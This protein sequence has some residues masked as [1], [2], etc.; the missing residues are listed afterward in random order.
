MRNYTD[1]ELIVRVWDQEQIRDLISRFTYFEAA[2]RRAEALDRF[3][4][5]SPEHKATAS[6]GR[7]WG[8]ITGMDAIRDYYVDR[9]RFGGVGTGLMHPLSTKLICLAG[10][11]LTARGMW[12][13]IAYETA[14]DAKGELEA[15]WINERL[16]VD[17]VKEDGVWKI[18]HLFVGT[19]YVF[20]AGENYDDQPV[21]T[22]PVTRAEGGPDWY[23]YGHGRE[24]TEGLVALFDQIPDYAER[25]SFL[26]GRT[27]EEIYT[28]LYNDPVTFPPLPEEYE[29][30]D[31]AQGYGPEGFARFA[32][33][34]LGRVF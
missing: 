31:P 3:W 12:M 15:K 10:D 19:N 16:A 23:T 30:Y 4:V 18:W 26:N 13:G 34:G 25:E 1:E 14:P 20:S 7:N 11:G 21:I 33:S 22:R 6:F 8:F 2:N 9:N 5:S 27:P 28:A 17:F 24:A 32:G 29:S